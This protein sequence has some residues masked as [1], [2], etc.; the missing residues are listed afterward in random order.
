MGLVRYKG[1]ATLKMKRNT[2]GYQDK[3]EKRTKNEN[4]SEYFS[5]NNYTDG[6]YRP[7]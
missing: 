6:R 3:E 5:N 7:L 4:K 1:L 2:T